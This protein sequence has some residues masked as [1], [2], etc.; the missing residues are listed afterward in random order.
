MEDEISWKDVAKLA[1]NL[2]KE[3]TVRVHLPTRRLHGVVPR[4]NESTEENQEV[5]LNF[6]NPLV[7][8]NVTIRQSN[9]FS[10]R[11]ICQGVQSP[12]S[13]NKAISSSVQICE[14][15][16]SCELSSDIPLN[17][18]ENDENWFSAV[19][20]CKH[21]NQA[22][23][24]EQ[25]WRLKADRAREE[26]EDKAEII[27]ALKRKV[28]ELHL[29]LNDQLQEQNNDREVIRS[30]KGDNEE[31]KKKLEW[32][33]KQ[34]HECQVVRDRYQKE[35]EKERQRSPKS[36]GTEMF[37]PERKPVELI[38]IEPVVEL[39]EE[40]VKTQTARLTKRIIIEDSGIQETPVSHKWFEEEKATWEA[41]VAELEGQI[42]TLKGEVEN[43]SK[44]L[45]KSEKERSTWLGRIAELQERLKEQVAESERLRDKL[46]VSEERLSLEEVSRRNSDREKDETQAML[47]SA[48]KEKSIL[49]T[50]VES[51]KE[52]FERVRRSF[53]VLRSRLVQKEKRLTE[54]EDILQS[55]KESTPEIK[56][57]GGRAGDSFD[58][59]ADNTEKVEMTEEAL[60]EWETWSHNGREG[61]EQIGKQE[62]AIG[63][64][65]NKSILSCL[66]K[67][68][69]GSFV[70][71]LSES[72]HSVFGASPCCLSAMERV[73]VEWREKHRTS[74]RALMSKM[75]EKLRK[76]VQTAQE[77]EIVVEPALQTSQIKLS[78]PLPS[79]L[80][81]PSPV[82]FDDSAILQLVE[83]SQKVI[84]K[85]DFTVNTLKASLSC[86]GEEISGLENQLKFTFLPGKTY[87]Y[88]E[89]AD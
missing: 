18:L 32:N 46:K 35:L 22:R 62:A 56:Q 2:K 74:V 29:N 60:L 58:E 19:D 24:R 11:S 44:S 73:D 39:M 85:N 63:N 33:Q 21:C 36:A 70:Q 28:A 53:D 1:A 81:L 59:P 4:V 86:L 68:N 37:P 41:M 89:A 88:I 26:A 31:L 54:L 9:D 5:Q 51:I 27:E 50:A 78:R 43:L 77:K 76:T 66:D 30:L 72:Q 6:S 57:E 15:T 20:N 55:Q 84:I 45:E 47:A 42:K 79:F 3:E 10:K 16:S 49:D 25:E 61:E 38:R 52:E 14:N 17:L 71:P 82:R 67:R 48:L 80:E 13:G 7:H 8:N 64:E 12:T 40:D 83:E 69:T 75:K 65:F 87:R 23:Q 34:L